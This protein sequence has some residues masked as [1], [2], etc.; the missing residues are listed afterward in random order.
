MCLSGDSLNTLR[1]LRLEKKVLFW[2]PFIE[3]ATNLTILH[4]VGGGCLFVQPM[5]IEH[6]AEMEL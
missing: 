1:Y 5:L 4:K 3:E 2:I 6:I